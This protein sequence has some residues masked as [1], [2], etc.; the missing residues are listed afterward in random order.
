M[1]QLKLNKREYQNSHAKYKQWWVFAVIKLLSVT[2]LWFRI[3]L[4]QHLPIVFTVNTCLIFHRIYSRINIICRTSKSLFNFIFHYSLNLLW[5]VLIT[6][7]TFGVSPNLTDIS[8]TIF[9]LNHIKDLKKLI[10][11]FFLPQ[12]LLCFMP[13]SSSSG[14]YLFILIMIHLLSFNSF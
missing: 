10:S 13:C 2:V 9:V 5:L 3:N 1:D 8:H 4:Q 6:F 14:E 11:P 12:F 7:I